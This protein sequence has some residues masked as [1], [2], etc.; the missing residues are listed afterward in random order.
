MWNLQNQSGWAHEERNRSVHPAIDQI[1]KTNFNALIQSNR[2]PKQDVKA[3]EA[4]A[5][6]NIVDRYELQPLLE[7][8]ALAKFLPALP[9]PACP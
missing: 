5:I 6:I 1:R 4:A 8:I 2:N 3:E 9:F 7:P